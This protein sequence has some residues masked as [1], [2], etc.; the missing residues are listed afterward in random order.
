ME[1]E[2][3]IFLLLF[4]SLFPLILDN[5]LANLERRRGGE[6]GGVSIS[7]KPREEEG[8]RENEQQESQDENVMGKRIK[9]FFPL[10]E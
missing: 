5:F 7:L 3:P 10:F 6:F 1:K 4:L 2:N 8:E 9:V